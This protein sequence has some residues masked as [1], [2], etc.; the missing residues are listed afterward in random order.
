MSEYL[1]KAQANF[2]ISIDLHDDRREIDATWRLEC[3]R[4]NVAVA[5]AEAAERQAAA[6]ERIDAHFKNFNAL[7]EKRLTHIADSL[8]AV[9][10]TM[11][12]NIAGDLSRI[13]VSLEKLDRC[14]FM[15]RTSK[16][17]EV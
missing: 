14:S 7:I 16:E 8:G 15:V 3:A 5:Q 11:A 9:D 1:D 2:E 10:L 12:S 17:G 13:A 4:L 6:M